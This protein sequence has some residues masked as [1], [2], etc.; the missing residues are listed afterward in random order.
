MFFLI[1]LN[2]TNAQIQNTKP[3]VYQ[4]Y[5]LVKLSYTFKCY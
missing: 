5:N 4:I 1:Q 3:L 2:P